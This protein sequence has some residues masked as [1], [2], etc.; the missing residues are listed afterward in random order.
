MTMKNLVITKI[1]INMKIF[2]TFIAMLTLTACN[3]I[4]G[5]GK[6]IQSTAEYTKDIMPAKKDNTT[7]KEKQ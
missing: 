4:G 1:G 5:L 2:I 7:A 6:D 3:T